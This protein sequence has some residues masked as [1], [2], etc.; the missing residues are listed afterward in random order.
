[1][2][3]VGPGHKLTDLRPYLR[4]QQRLSNFGNSGRLLPF[5]VETCRYLSD[6]SRIIQSIVNSL[7]VSGYQGISHIVSLFT[8]VQTPSTYNRS[9]R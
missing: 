9:N 4:T 2:A 6:V 3:D 5:I 1:M 8:Y 7:L